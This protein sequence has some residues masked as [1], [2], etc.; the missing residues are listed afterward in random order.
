M[1]YIYQKIISNIDNN[2]VNYNGKKLSKEFNKEFINRNSYYNIY[3]YITTVKIKNKK[4]NFYKNRLK[5]IKKYY[6][7]MFSNDD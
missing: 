6:K 7:D 2:I 1:Q 4:F 5:K 3:N